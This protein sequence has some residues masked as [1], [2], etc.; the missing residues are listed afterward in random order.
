VKPSLQ[1]RLS[2]SLTLT[3]QLQQSIKLLQISTLELQ[4]EIGQMLLENPLLEQVDPDYDALDHAEPIAK[5]EVVPP[6]QEQYTTVS[7]TDEKTEDFGEGD[8]PDWAD[9]SNDW[10]GNPEAPDEDNEQTFSHAEDITLRAHLL[11]Q[12]SMMKEEPLVL[13]WVRALIDALNDDG[14]LTVTREECNE[15]VLEEQRIEAD[16][17]EQV[18]AAL[19]TLDPVGVGARHLQECLRL[20]LE[21]LPAST[22]YASLALD[23]INLHFE[24]FKAR[25]FGRLKRLF[26]TEEEIIKAACELISKQNPRPGAQYTGAAASYVLPDI[27]VR[28]Q[29]KR[30]VASLNP[31]TV[32]KLRIN[33]VYANIL[34]Q[35]KQG[36]STPMST[37]LQ[38]A[39][40]MIKNIE[41]RFTT[42]LRVGQAI[43]ERQQA[44]FEHGEIAMRPLVLREIADELELHESTISRVTSA[45]YMITQRGVFE[46]KYFFGSG[47]ATDTGGAASA[48]AIKAMLKQM[49]AAE[50]KKKPLNDSKLTELLE[51]Q[52]IMVARRTVAKYREMAGIGSVAERREG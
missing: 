45:K 24:H 49:V 44:F 28:K 12:M 6:L 8:I 46:L 36:R 25:D 20:Q 22:P 18:V 17:W 9:A 42:I 7:A 48:M 23:I 31:S 47:V 26:R 34:S 16:V 37:Q 15:L 1:L 52:G 5:T 32:P 11:G 43:V 50:D 35:N 30:W 41:Q 3:P 10:P 21:V 39:R 40:W 13:M 33:Q 4:Q 27:V 51:A 29:R 2:Q 19:Q 14:Y 38:E